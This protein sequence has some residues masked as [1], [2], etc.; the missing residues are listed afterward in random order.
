MQHAIVGNVKKTLAGHKQIKLPA[1]YYNHIPWIFGIILC[2]MGFFISLTPYR[3]YLSYLFGLLIIV[4]GLCGAVHVLFAFFAPRYLVELVL[5]K[6]LRKRDECML[7]HIDNL[8]MGEFSIGK[9]DFKLRE[10]TDKAT[11]QVWKFKEGDFIFVER[12]PIVLVAGHSG[13]AIP[14]RYVQVLNN[15]RKL[16]IKTKADLSRYLNNKHNAISE[17]QKELNELERDYSINKSNEIKEQIA[18]KE[19]ELQ[20]E[21][22]DIKQIEEAINELPLNTINLVEVTKY[23]ANENPELELA[24]NERY[25]L[26]GKLSAMNDEAFIALL[27]YGILFAMIIGSVVLGFIMIKQYV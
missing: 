1:L 23:L 27:K 20:K 13:K 17:I 15:L 19:K 12:I 26:A 10:V 5:I 16:G 4:F 6:Y 18:H 2:N 14:V 21:L 11:G 24:K 22:D 9:I 3:I 25:Y 8:G 7:F